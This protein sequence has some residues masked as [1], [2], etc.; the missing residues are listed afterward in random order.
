MHIN[1]IYYT[2]DHYYC[3]FI[4]LLLLILRLLRLLSALDNNN[5]VVGE[6]YYHRCCYYYYYTDFGD[7]KDYSPLLLYIILLRVRRT[8]LLRG[9]RFF[10][11][12]TPSTPS[13]I[14][15]KNDDGPLR[16]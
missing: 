15:C 10:R 1:I 12:V 8:P 9:K 2:L 5:S 11:N 6:N 16:Q 3:S 13:F 4:I 14:R 7:A